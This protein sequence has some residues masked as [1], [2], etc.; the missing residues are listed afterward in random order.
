MYRPRLRGRHLTLLRHPWRG[1]LGARGVR[2]QYRTAARR[3][4]KP[5]GHRGARAAASNS[6][7]NDGGIPQDEGERCIVSRDRD[8]LY[9]RTAPLVVVVVRN[10]LAWITSFTNA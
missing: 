8:A 1:A 6:S 4:N 2:E 3:R 10:P 9:T 5:L 7:A